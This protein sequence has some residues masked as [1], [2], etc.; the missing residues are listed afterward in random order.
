MS[1]HEP[2]NPSRNRVRTAFEFEFS[3]LPPTEADCTQA[4]RKSG[5]TLEKYA[6][7]A[8][9]EKMLRDARPYRNKSYAQPA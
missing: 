8:F 6:Y 5:E 3:D 9:N 7:A 1:A 2:S 4:L